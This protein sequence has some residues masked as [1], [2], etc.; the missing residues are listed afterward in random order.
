MLASATAARSASSVASA[1]TGDAA[2]RREGCIREQTACVS[3]S[4]GRIRARPD[5]SKRRVDAGG[6][7]RAERERRPVAFRA[8]ERHEHA[9]SVRPV[10]R[11]TAERRHVRR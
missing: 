4:A 2:M 11:R 10:R 7:L 6:E 9:R 3:Q 5:E 1:R 8:A